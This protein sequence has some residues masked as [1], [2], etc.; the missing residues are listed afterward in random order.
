MPATRAERSALLSPQ[1]RRRRA[2]Q[3]PRRRA[4][5]RG[6]R[7][8]RPRRPRPRAPARGRAAA[9]DR[10]RRGAG[11]AR[12]VARARR[13]GGPAGGAGGLARGR[14]RRGRD[15]GAQ[16]RTVAP[17]TPRPSR[18]RW[19]G[20][21]R[22]CGRGC[23]AR[24]NAALRAVGAA[25]TVTAGLAR[26]QRRQDRGELV[27]HVAVEPH[28]G[29]AVERASRSGGDDRDRAAGLQGQLRQPGD[30]EDLER[31]ADAEQQVGAARR[32]R[33]RAPSPPRRA[34]RRTAR[35]PASA[36]ARSRSAARRRR[37]PPAAR[38][39]PP[40]GS[41]R[42]RP[43]TRRTRSTRGPR[44]RR[45]SRP[46]ACRPSMFWVIT[47]SS[48]PACLEL[49]ERAVGA[50]RLLALEHGEARPVERPEALRAR[51]ARRRCARPPSGRRSPTARCRA[52][53]SRGCPRAPRCRRR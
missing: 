22:R 50:V 48:R 51:G 26:L 25:G 40:A 49:G 39:S 27:L 41:A 34:A 6:A 16:G 44:S 30:R 20:S 15:G 28:G 33:S 11:R 17:P 23:G 36:A 2:A 32:A 24:A 46:R 12:G 43:G 52:S 38:A 18:P 21:R 19:G 1:E 13:H 14:G 47:A 10:A 53:G 3:R 35:R 4:R 42:R 8:A 45:A 29:E 5:V 37:P 9:R 31:G 7:P